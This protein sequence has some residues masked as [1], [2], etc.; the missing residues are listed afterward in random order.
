MWFAQCHTALS[1]ELRL[2]CRFDGLQRAHVQGPHCPSFSEVPHWQRYSWVQITVDN[3][4]V[5]R[6]RAWVICISTCYSAAFAPGCTVRAA[7]S[8]IPHGGSYEPVPSAHGHG[9]FPCTSNSSHIFS[10]ELHLRVCHCYRC[11]LH[12]IDPLGRFGVVFFVL[13]LA[14][15]LL[16]DI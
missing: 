15:P 2:Q 3:N 12:R 11:W 8:P 16:L 14:I 4:I 10:R 5:S 1:G 7:P 13:F 9:S 6:V